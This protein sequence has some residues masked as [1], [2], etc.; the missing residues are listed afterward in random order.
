MSNCCA[1]PSC[2]TEGI[3]RCSVCLREPY[4]SGDC[5]NKDWKVHKLICK[6]LQ[7]LPNH[8]QPYHKVVQTI[9]EILASEKAGQDARILEHLLS[10]AL[11]QFAD[12][13]S[14][15]NSPIYLIN[16]RERINGERISNWDV[17][18][19]NIYKIYRRLGSILMDKNRL[20][21]NLIQD[22]TV[23]PCFTKMLELL[24]P[25]YR[26]MDLD[27]I[28][29]ILNLDKDQIDEISRILILGKDQIDWILYLLIDTEVNMAIIYT[30][31]NE[32]HLAD[33]HCKRL[34]SYSKKFDGKAEQKTAHL[35]QAYTI[36][37]HL[38]MQQEN[39]TDAVLFAEEAYNCAAIS[40][41]PVHP[42]VQDAAGV[43]IDC[44]IAKGELYDAERYS[45]L[46]LESLKDL[47]NGIDQNSWELARGYSN[48]ASVI[49][50]QHGDLAKAESLAREAHRISMYLEAHGE[51]ASVLAISSDLLGRVLLAADKLGEETMKLLEYTLAEQIRN[52]GLDGART[53]ICHSNLG[54]LH[55]SLIFRQEKAERRK[56]QVNLAKSY[57]SEAVRISTKIYGSGHPKTI[58][59]TSRLELSHQQCLGNMTDKE[60]EE[61]NARNYPSGFP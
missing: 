9:S 54:N 16:Y 48:L 50:R 23:I 44:L 12:Q 56:E 36:Y 32:F 24:M 55:L 46:T 3:N 11:L 25:W 20:N 27:E 22:D 53:A 37:S 38:R 42:E 60:I 21:I 18:I 31:R 8:L 57:C 45:L 1:R 58:E 30:N 51:K 59:F 10:Y 13:D 17:E 4:C 29:R 47:A 26:L 19:G 52:E 61:K 40:Y 43:L 14:P 2:Q 34:L 49:L 15:N 35:C 7:K 28:S 41:N 6:T 5:Q 39:F 33:D